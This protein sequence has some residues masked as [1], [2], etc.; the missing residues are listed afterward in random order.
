MLALVPTS[1]AYAQAS[2]TVTVNGTQGGRVFDGIGAISGGGGNTALLTSYPPAQQQA[3]L[4]Y[5]FKP[6]Y[7]AALQVLKVEI[8]SDTNS[9]D[10][11]ESSIE[12]TQGSIDCNSGYEWWLMEQ[13]QARNPAIKFYGLAWGAPGWVGSTFW[14]TN[15]IN[16]IVA[17]L[18]CAKSHGLTISYLGGWN[19]HGF[20]TSWY[21]QLRSAL[22]S[23]GYSGVQVV[24]ADSVGWSVAS[25]MASDQ[26]FNNAVQVVGVH[27]PCGYLS[28][29]TSCPSTS[30]AVGLNKPLWA[31]E[32]GSQDYNNGAGA[33][34]RADNRDYIDGRM[35]ATLNW[36]LV[37]AIYTNMKFDTDGLVLANQP[38]SGA[39]TVGKQTWVTA[40]TTQFAQPG[41]SYIDS[42][43]GYL[44]GNRSDG[45]YVTLKSPDHSDWSSV[46]ETMDATAAQTVTYNV[47]GG[48]STGAVHVWSTDVSSTNP[49]T[50]F[51]HSQDITPN[52]GSFSL[53][54]QPGFVY[55]VTTTTGQGKGTAVSPS[56]G[57]L[58]LPYSDSFSSDPVD[59]QPRYFTQQQGSFQVEPCTGGR[60]G[61]CLTQ[62]TLQQPILWTANSNPYTMGGNLGW[63]NYTVSADALLEQAGS[64]QVIGRVGAHPSEAPADVNDYYLQVSNTGAWSIVRSSTSP[65]LT[66]LASGTVSAPGTG[67]WT[68]LSLT[69][70]GSSI[71]GAINGHTVA[72]VSDSGYAA[73]MA[74]LG[75][76]G[77][78]GAQFANLSVTPVGSQAPTGPIVAGDDSSKCVDDRGFGTANG[79]V[80][81]MWDCNGGT[82]QQWTIETDGTIQVFGKCLDIVGGDTANGTLVD[83]WT[84]NGGTNQQWKAANGTLVNP[85]SGKC[86]DDP[87]FNTANG[88]QLDIWTCNGGTNQQWTL[89]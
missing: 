19:E 41:W 87:G 9:T 55:S 71:S 10:G 89:P 81:E 76:A 44:Q 39:Y 1:S 23:A 69:L 12:H 64:A 60:T 47:T 72:T 13:A 50:W 24:A 59:V 83:L 4:D 11:S 66:T 7:G 85:A 32:N 82:N 26:V 8:G 43:S 52:N 25:S 14:T 15:T 31:S 49:A 68:H 78:T 79:T 53:T 58:S 56:P 84:C 86:L 73:G 5:L 6:G 51:V 70:N 2:T 46:I 20:Q 17:W 16:Y 36:P 38:W 3:I 30:T 88:T 62:Q 45:S 57:P 54:V 28:S 80:V 67:T 34:A 75:T 37:A 65:S 33:M 22:N 21:E 40:Q 48:L 35:T 77:Y 61:N 74:G 18:N 42:A 27:Y 29:E 63:T